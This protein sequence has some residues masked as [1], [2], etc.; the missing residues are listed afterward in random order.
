MDLTPVSVKALD[1]FKIWIEFNDGVSGEIYLSRFAEQI[2]FEPWKD[3]GVFESV[4][5]V[6]YEV[7]VWGDDGETDMGL[8]AD[9]LYLELTG[10]SW[11]EVAGDAE[12]QVVNARALSF[13]RVRRLHL[14][15]RP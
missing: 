2:W 9:A 8:C 11:E 15:R 7:V 14:P 3:R 4:R 5:I 13:R 6:P 10:R 1:G 12:R